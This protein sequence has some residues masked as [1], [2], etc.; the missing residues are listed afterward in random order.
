MSSSH[1]KKAPRKRSRSVAW[2]QRERDVAAFHG[3]V[4]N[5]LSGANSGRVGDCYDPE[6]TKPWVY[7]EC[8]HY[9]AHSAISILEKHRDQVRKVDKSG[10]CIAALS[11]NRRH[12]FYTLIHNSDLLLYAIVLL[13]KHGF[14]VTRKEI[15][16]AAHNCLG[17]GEDGETDGEDGLALREISDGDVL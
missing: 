17:D 4:R 13:K 6:T 7:I 2:K 1:K 3:L 8:K 10:L 5:P 15:A 11:E 16:D 9:E 14:E 12:G